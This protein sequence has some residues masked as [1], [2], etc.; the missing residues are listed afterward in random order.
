MYSPAAGM[1]ETADP[2]AVGA[3]AESD[4]ISALAAG[5]DDYLTKPIGIGVLMARLGVMVRRTAPASIL[6]QS[7]RW[8]V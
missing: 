5:A 6:N 3:R 1:D 2:R 4:K 7:F 8:K